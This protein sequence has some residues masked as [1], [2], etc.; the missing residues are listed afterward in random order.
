MAVLTPDPLPKEKLSA[1][2]KRGHSL[3]HLSP[4]DAPEKL[5]GA[6]GGP[7]W[8]V[9]EGLEGAFF[10]ICLR[11]DCG[12]SELWKQAWA[13]QWPPGEWTW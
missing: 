7:L 12:N 5:A 9:V 1:L 3:L 4:Q 2:A 6:V 11:T 13:S 8:K 10:F